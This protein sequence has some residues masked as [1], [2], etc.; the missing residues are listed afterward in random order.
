MVPSQYF[1]QIRNLRQLKTVHVH[2]GSGENSEERMS[3]MYTR[4]DVL[5]YVEENDVKFIRLAF[6]DVKGVQRNISIMPGRLERAFEK[7]IALDAGIVP[8][9]E[10]GCQSDL[11]LVP[12]PS[13]MMLLPWRSMDN[14]VIHMI[15][16]LYTPD[17]EIFRRDTRQILKR[18]IGRA[19][20]EGLDL[21]MAAK[22]EFYLFE[23]DE[24]GHPTSIPFDEGGYMDI[25]PKD[26]GENIRREIC[27][28][29]DE[30]G[31]DPHKSYHQAGPGQNEIDFHFSDPLSSADE[32][33]IFKWVVRTCAHGSG[34]AADFSP[35]PLKDAPGNGLHIQIRFFDLDQERQDAFLAGIL[36]YAGE[37]SLFFN[38]AEESYLRLGKDR[39]PGK[40]DWSRTYRNVMVRLPGR[41]N[42][43]FEMRMGDCMANPYLMFALLIEAGLKGMDENLSLQPSFEEDENCGKPLPASLSEARRLAADSVFIH[44]IVPEEIIDFYMAEQR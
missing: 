31:L 40:A 36:R 28:T 27:L 19:Y 42:S 38:P 35:R 15:C 9:F 8:G 30:M 13:T 24:K 20:A 7:G 10:Q 39:A 22:F 14:G 3:K 16:D 1:P 6:F 37:S 23:L 29:L 26:R 18:A 43:T 17:G 34:L 25:A 12:D 41:S 11:F 33:S 2:G 21:Q 44:E 4:E 32:A 5:N